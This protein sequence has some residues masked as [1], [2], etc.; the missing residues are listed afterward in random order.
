MI[1]LRNKVNIHV[2]NQQCG[3]AK[4]IDRHPMF[5]SFVQSII[6]IDY[7][8]VYALFHLAGYWISP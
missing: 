8:F 1:T 4:T 7:V 5:W 6:I 3:E 2:D